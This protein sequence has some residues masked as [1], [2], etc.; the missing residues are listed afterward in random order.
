MQKIKRDLWTN[1]LLPF[2]LLWTI[3][4]TGIGLLTRL[5]LSFV[6]APLLPTDQTLTLSRLL[7]IILPSLGQ[8]IL[9]E[10]LL[11]RSMRG[12]MLY[13]LP[14][15]LLTLILVPAALTLPNPE[16]RLDLYILL[17]V[18]AYIVPTPVLQ[19]FWLRSRVK[20]AWLWPLASFLTALA[21]S[22]FPSNG[23]NSL[24]LWL[25]LTLI[26][27]LIQG[28]VM[29]TLWTHAKETEKV[30]VEF[31]IDDESSRDADRIER[32]QTSEHRPS[33]T[34]HLPESQST[35]ENIRQ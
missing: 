27:G 5:F 22:A 35:T 26:Y 8:I 17:S 20:R 7:G 6:L 34:P 31:D 21:F 11:K 33:A 29:H 23:T 19:A 14:G 4:L 24:G 15:A 16:G 30:K 32:L 28:T 18:L 25:I 9:V 3:S 2:A 12:W 10:R 1:R 13:T